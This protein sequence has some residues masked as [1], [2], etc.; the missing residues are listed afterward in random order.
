MAEITTAPLPGDLDRPANDIVLNHKTQQ[1]HSGLIDSGSSFSSSGPSLVLSNNQSKSSLS[2]TLSEQ[3]FDQSHLKPGKRASLLSYS[4]TLNMY[5]ENL[6]KTNNPEVQCN[7]A[8]FLIEAGNQLG[9]QDKHDYYSEAEKLL[10][11]LAFKGHPHAQYQLAK[12]YASG[13]FSKKNGK[14]EY[15][16]AFSLYVQASKRDH[17]DATFE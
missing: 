3:L 11:Q 15:Q 14:P 2:S 7:F 4:Q 12:L 13:V 16:K 17:M 9:Q 10:K 6:K 5:R 1:H 8:L